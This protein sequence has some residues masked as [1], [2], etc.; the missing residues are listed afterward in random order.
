VLKLI[1]PSHQILISRCVTKRQRR[2]TNNGKTARAGIYTQRKWFKDYMRE[3]GFDWTPTMKVG[4]GCQ[5]HLRDG[6]LPM[7]RLVVNVSRHSVAVIDRCVYGY[8]KLR[9][10]WHY[11]DLPKAGD[12]VSPLYCRS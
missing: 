5:V 9:D 6:E 12:P 3:I 1:Y 4:S 11:D 7:G 10:G 8:W 2:K